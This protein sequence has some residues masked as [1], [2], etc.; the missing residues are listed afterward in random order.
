MNRRQFILATAALATFG[1]SSPARA[2]LGL[3]FGD[4]D[5]D[6]LGITSLWNAGE[7]LVRGFDDITPEQEY[8]IGRS[9]AAIILSKYQP[10]NVPKVTRYLTALGNSLAMG[11]SRP[12]TFGGYCFQV[13]DSAEINAL[14]AP[15]GFVF[16]TRGLLRCCDSEDA[17]AAVLAHEIAHIAHK[18]G[19]QAIQDARISSSLSTIAQAGATLSGGDL[20]MVTEAFGGAIADVTTTM[21]DSGYSRDAEYEA[22]QSALATMQRVGYDPQ[23]MVA[24]LRTMEVQLTDDST[25]FGKTHPSP[26]DRIEE[27]QET[28]GE[29]FVPDPPAVRYERFNKTMGTV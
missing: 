21:I 8:Y 18:H 3:G 4:D 17:V 6:P 29:Y 10:Y 22:D 20:G 2:F 11:S 24:M 27:A 9:V 7:N 28:L 5:S 19:L 1:A 14:S 15:G 26:V 12:A 25:G 13:L 23:A 16:I